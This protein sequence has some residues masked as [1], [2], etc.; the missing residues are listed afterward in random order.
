MFKFKIAT[1]LVVLFSVASATSV[2]PTADV[3]PSIEV[4]TGSVNPPSGCVNITVVSSDCRNL[5]GRLSFLNKEIST[6]VVPDG[7]VCTFFQDFNCT[8]S[9]TGNAGTDSE[10]VLQ[11]GTWDLSEAPG[12]SGSE[13][14]SDLTSSFAC[15]PI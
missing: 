6:A 13:D 15:S 8:A 1:T 2:K 5:A 10:V 12:L 7:L 9:G 14:F 3:S 11:G 4:C